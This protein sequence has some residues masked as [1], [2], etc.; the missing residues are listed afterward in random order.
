MRE[1]PT[2][3]HHKETMAQS[4]PKLQNENNRAT[5]SGTAE[6][7]KK[8]EVTPFEAAEKA[9]QPQMPIVGEQMQLFGEDERLLDE[10]ARARHRLIGQV[11]DTYWMVEYDGKLFI[12]DQHAA[13]EKVL[14]EK[15][16]KAFSKKALQKQMLSPPVILTLSMQEE[17][18]YSRYEDYFAELG[19]EVESFGGREYAV[20]GVPLQLFG[21]NAKDIFIEIL[22]SLTEE[23]RRLDGSAITEHIATMDCKAAVKGNNKLSFKEADA[24]IEQLLQAKNPYTCPHGRPTIISLS[25][26]ELEKKFKRIQS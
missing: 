13:H 5:M 20:C 11:F 6:E 26:Y 1:T 15:L 9:P 18:I 4:T 25:K 22:D 23:S 7:Q 21:M 8:T 19:F 14:Y 12:I 17:N 16:M 24:L 10:K 2:A 3:Y